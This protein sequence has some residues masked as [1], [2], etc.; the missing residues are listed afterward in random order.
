MMDPATVAKVVDVGAASIP[1]LIKLVATIFQ[2]LQ[3][4]V[5]L[6]ADEIHKRVQLELDAT[7]KALSEAEERDRKLYEA[8]HPNG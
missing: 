3:D 4:K 5:G 8:T 7:A 2:F 1:V 6:S